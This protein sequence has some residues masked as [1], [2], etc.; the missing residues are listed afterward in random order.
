MATPQQQGNPSLLDTLAASALEAY[1]NDEA[2][3]RR[4]LER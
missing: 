4:A 2:R 3:I 1:P